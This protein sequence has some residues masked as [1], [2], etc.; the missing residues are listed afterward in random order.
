MHYWK[1]LDAWNDPFPWI[2]ERHVTLDLSTD[3]SNYKWGAVFHAPDN[4]IEFSD[5]WSPEEG[6]EIIMF[7]EA[8][9]LFK[10]LAS[11]KDVI[12]STR[13]CVSVDKAVVEA[14]KNQYSKNP[15]V[16]CVFK[17]IF[18]LIMEVK[19]I[20][21]LSYVPSADNIADEPS[22][23]LSKSDCTITKRTWALVEA[24]QFNSIL[25]RHTQTYT[26]I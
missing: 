4:R 11:L 10:A 3:A 13:L 24:F 26:H 6:D 21:T 1:F 9:A 14:W 16:N 17:Q 25:F 2:R 18:Q 12:K 22:R 5:F 15:K 19:C 20:L 7:K 23:K 8:M